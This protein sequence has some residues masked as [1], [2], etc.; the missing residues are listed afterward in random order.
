MPYDSRSDRLLSKSQA[1]AVL[2]TVRHGVSS[3][4]T[5]S[6]SVA[7]HCCRQPDAIWTNCGSNKCPAAV[8]KH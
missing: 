3:S 6:G 7:A 5:G 1:S 2:S 4:A 8:S